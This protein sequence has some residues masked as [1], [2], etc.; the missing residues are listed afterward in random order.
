LELER[1]ARPSDPSDVFEALVRRRE[2]RGRFRRLRAGLLAVAAIGA[3]TAG[4]V[5]LSG[6]MGGGQVAGP[7]ET[8]GR[9]VFR[10]VE[11]QLS[12]DGRSSARG[13][14]GIWSI[15]PDGSDLRL[16]SPAERGATTPA[17]SPD[18][19]RIAVLEPATPDD[20]LDL[21]LVTMLGDGSDRRLIANG[22]V[23]PLVG[24]VAW[25]PDGTR[26]A[27]LDTAGDA[28]GLAALD[29]FGLPRTDIA[30]YSADGAFERFVDIPGSVVGFAW[31]PDGSGFVATRYGDNEPRSI[32]LVRADLDGR[33]LGTIA[34]DV[35]YGASPAFSPDGSR[36]AYV[37]VDPPS[38]GPDVVG[39]VWVANGDGTNAARITEDGGRKPSLAWSPDGAG[40]L[41]AWQTPEMC[42]IVSIAPDGS[43]RVVLA[44]RSTMGGCAQELS[45]QPSGPAPVPTSSPSP[46][47]SPS[48]R[49]EGLDIGLGVRFCD[50]EV[51]SGIDWDGTGIDGSAWTGAPVEEDGTCASGEL[52]QHV[53]AVDRNGDGLA[54]R[55]S[56]STL[57]SCLFCR[58]FDTVDLN[59]DGVL[60]LVVLEEASST[61]TYSVYEVN[62]PGSERAEGV[63]PIIMIPPGAPEMG[64]DPNELVRFTVGGDEGFSG[65]I[66]CE[67]G[68][69]GPIIR[70]TWVR[71]EVD[72]DTDLQV[73]ITM[74]RFGDDGVFHVESVD[75]FSVPRDPEPTELTSTD[76]ACGVD[77]HPD[78]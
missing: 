19:R 16:V 42:G 72:A 7:S 75:S 41:Y 78:A 3:T 38:F 25:S 15:E 2:L 58:P 46:T 50:L 1:V 74:L 64:L 43:D 11:L 6:L 59:D 9:I 55:G 47:I 5:A 67:D 26:I 30:I 49:G 37:R 31:V 61:P 66:E 53:V 12:E 10:R 8:G 52:A 56:T 45:V 27:V 23:S 60:E 62:R 51:L 21:T 48:P 40:I 77:F 69:D 4:L 22:L 76:P 44:D 73:D 63:Y 35:L 28:E 29:E 20:S 33:I 14:S 13:E 57:R 34:E 24:A 17:W 71:G 36:I 39:D 70:Y 65:G 32:D 68:P 54:E 18:G